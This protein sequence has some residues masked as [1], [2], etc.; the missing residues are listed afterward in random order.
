MQQL[1]EQYDLAGIGLSGFGTE[2]D[3]AQ[4]QAA[5]FVRYLT[6]PVRFEQLK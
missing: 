4:G 3:I 5:G 1:K 6:K 2:E